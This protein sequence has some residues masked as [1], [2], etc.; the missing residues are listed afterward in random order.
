MAPRKIPGVRSAGTA[1]HRDVLQH[2]VTALP[3][4]CVELDCAGG[5]ESQVDECLSNLLV[6]RLGFLAFGVVGRGGGFFL[7]PRRVIVAARTARLKAMS[8][9]VS[10][11]WVALTR[12]VRAAVGGYRGR[13]ESG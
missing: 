7:L 10:L 1:P 5:S 2:C 4:Y 11:W 9:S 8:G 3:R 12:A 6:G 13:G